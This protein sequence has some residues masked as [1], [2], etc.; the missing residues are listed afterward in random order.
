MN[1]RNQF[2]FCAQCFATGIDDN[3]Q[4]K[5][6]TQTHIKIYTKTVTHCWQ[7]PTISSRCQSKNQLALLPPLSHSPLFSVAVLFDMIL[8]WIKSKSKATVWYVSDSQCVP[9]NHSFFLRFFFLFYFS[10]CFVFGS[11]LHIKIKMT[12][13]KIYKHQWRMSYIW[14]CTFIHTN[15]MCI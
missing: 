8:F 10:I 11:S 2:N 9:Q 7:R 14:K 13:D 1:D 15:N 12:H 6:H 4:S 3:L 5:P